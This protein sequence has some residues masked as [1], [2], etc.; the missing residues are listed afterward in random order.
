MSM[1]TFKGKS[2]VAHLDLGKVLD[3]K[4]EGGKRGLESAAQFLVGQ[5]K[6]EVSKPGPDPGTD[7]GKK[8]QRRLERIAAAGD[9]QRASKPGEPPHRRTGTLRNSIGYEIQ[10]LLARVGTWLKY[11]YWLEWGTVKMEARPWLR[12]GLANNAKQIKDIV[13]A[14]M[15][16]AKV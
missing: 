10:G 16:A 6:E 5:L 7:K 12:P 11:G 3:A 15:R 14:F 9:V 13:F 2:Y 8:R 4:V 1:R